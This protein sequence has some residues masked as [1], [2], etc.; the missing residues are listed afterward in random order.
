M[1][2]FKHTYN[3]KYGIGV[4]IFALVI[5][6]GGITKT[7]NIKA[8]EN[9][10]NIVQKPIVT[11]NILSTSSIYINKTK[12][13]NI[14]PQSNAPERPKYQINLDQKYQDLIWQL[15]IK[16]NLSYEFV[17]AVFHYESKFNTTA[18]NKNKNHSVDFGVAQ[19]N[20]NFIDTYRGYAIEYCNLSPNEKFDIYNA[21]HSIRAGIGTIVYLR[22][23]WKQKGVSDSDIAEFVT[24]SYNL[25][26]LGFE[27]YIQRTGKIEREYSRQVEKRVN[28]LKTSNT[29]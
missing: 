6:G 8:E 2:K 4:L 14:V 26:V 23:Y 15:C 25:G 3:R 12:T 24:G 20:S 22:N 21:D 17:L 27:Q 28:L 29:L 11:M 7:K 18:T 1:R 13:V 5:T 10:Y 19:L 16:N 9:T